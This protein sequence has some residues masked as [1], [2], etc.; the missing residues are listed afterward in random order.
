MTE[1]F[2]EFITDFPLEQDFLQLTFT[3]S[4]RPIKQRW[5]NNR[6]SAHFVAD[7]FANFLP[8]DENDPSRERR[9][10]ESKGAV[11]YVANELLENAIKYNDENSNYKVKFGVHFVENI[12]DIIAVIFA[13]N[14]VK[15]GDV[16]K[17]KA[18]IEEL[19]SSDPN[20]M[21]ISQVEKSVEEDTEASG[22][23]L[24]TM[25]NDYGAKLGWSIDLIEGDSPVMTVTTMAQFKV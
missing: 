4:S 12:D 20:D 15:S 16:D 8:V 6:L 19:L 10:K 3:P 13:T 24:L 18:F 14:S 23:G 7:Y 21:Y 1:V 5:K 25:I 17:L 2:G 22:L 11:S 9:I